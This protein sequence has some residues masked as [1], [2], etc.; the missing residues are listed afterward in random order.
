MNQTRKRAIIETIHEL[1]ALA[2]MMSQQRCPVDTGALK[3]SGLVQH[4][5]QGSSIK[6][7]APYASIV[8]R[9][10][11]GGDIHVD[12]YYRS[13]GVF[14]KGHNKTLSPRQGTFFIDTSIKESFS[15]FPVLLEKR[16]KS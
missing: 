3:A 6:Y 9:G 15:S 16:L 13:D 10:Y 5:E 11:K 12:G 14:V 1:S 2:F 4:N 7:L 8:N